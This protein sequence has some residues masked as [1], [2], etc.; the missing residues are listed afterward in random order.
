MGMPQS[1]LWGGRDRAAR[2]NFA[3]TQHNYGKK[4]GAGY[5]V[6]SQTNASGFSENPILC[7]MAERK[8]C[9]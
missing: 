5:C 6:M 9:W 8:R 7:A 2:Q 1:D 4:T 3:M